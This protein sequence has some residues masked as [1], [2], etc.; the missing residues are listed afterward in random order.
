MTTVVGI[1]GGIGAGKTTLS[2]HLKKNGFLVHESDK[3][4]SKMYTKP[5]KSFKEFIKKNISYELVKNKKINK[6]KLTEIIFNNTTLKKRLEKH[7]HKEVR[8]SRKE[9]IQ[10][11]K[12]TKKNIIF[13]DI[14][15]LLENNLE[16]G[17]DLVVC[18]ISSKKNRTKRILK[19]KKFN[20]KTLNK[21]FRAQ[22]SD[23]DRRR[24]SQIIIN[25]NKTKKDFIFN[26]EQALI[27][28][29]K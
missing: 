24:R 10:K 26:A 29:L 18:I 8:L 20:K 6:K 14:P 19:N 13:V 17:L 9:F 11:N 23:K 5:K 22:T 15:L 7:I 25:N 4:V 2:E 3:V 27:G 28:L 16:L 1:T 21:I 12:K